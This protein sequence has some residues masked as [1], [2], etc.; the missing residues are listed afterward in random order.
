MMNLLGDI[1]VMDELGYIY[2]RDRKGDTFRWKGENCSTA[3][4]IS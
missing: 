4:V 2:F 3:E 1:L